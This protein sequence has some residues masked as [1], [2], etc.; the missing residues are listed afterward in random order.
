MCGNWTG[1]W[2]SPYCFPYGIMG[3]IFQLGILALIVWV[4]VTV[5]RNLTS[6]KTEVSKDGGT[7]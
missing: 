2:S 4:V 5:V 7:K 3:I 1:F 6:H